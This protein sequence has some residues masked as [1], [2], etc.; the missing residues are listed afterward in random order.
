MK[1][2]MKRQKKIILK[3]IRKVKDLILGLVAKK[4]FCEQEQKNVLELD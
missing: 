4:G 3:V 2:G 1:E